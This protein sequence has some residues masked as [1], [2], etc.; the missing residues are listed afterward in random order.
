VGLE[1]VVVRGQL[2]AE[3]A[4]GACGT[5]VARGGHRAVGVLGDGGELA[6]VVVV[7]RVEE[8]GGL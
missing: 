1:V 6:V 5:V 3:L 2:V 8:G 4:A 7:L